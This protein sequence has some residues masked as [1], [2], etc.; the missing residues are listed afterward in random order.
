MSGYASALELKQCALKRFHV[1][2]NF[3]ALQISNQIT[4][5]RLFSL[6]TYVFA[7]SREV[8]D[9]P[10]SSIL[11]LLTC[12][13][14]FPCMYDYVISLAVIAFVLAACQFMYVCVCVCVCVCV[15]MRVRACVALCFCVSFR[16]SVCQYVCVCV[17][18]CVWLCICVIACALSICTSVCGFISVCLCVCVCVCVC[19]FVCLC[20]CL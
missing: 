17:C 9:L 18:V 7:L 11:A 13:E 19:L 1:A 5:Q 6:W 10:E 2:L 16:A 3:N 20:V 4:F 15:R 8:G 12:C 14:L